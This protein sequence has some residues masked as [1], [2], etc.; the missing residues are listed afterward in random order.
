MIRSGARPNTLA[1]PL[2]RAACS[3]ALLLLFFLCGAKTLQNAMAE[4]NT[5]T[6]SVVHVDTPESIKVT[7]KRDGRHVAPAMDK[8]AHD[9]HAHLKPPAKLSKRFGLNKIRRSDDSAA[10]VAAEAATEPANALA[11]AL[12]REARARRQAT[13]GAAAPMAQ[14]A[15][16]FADTPAQPRLIEVA[17]HTTAPESSGADD[18]AGPDHPTPHQIILDRGY[19]QGPPAHESGPSQSQAPTADDAGTT[20]SISPSSSG[21]LPRNSWSNDSWSNDFW[22]NAPSPNSARPGSSWPAASDAPAGGESPLGY[23]EPPA[24]TAPQALL[25]AAMFAPIAPQREH[26]PAVVLTHRPPPATTI[27]VKRGLG[28]LASVVVSAPVVKQNQQ[29]PRPLL[30]RATPSIAQSSDPWLLAVMMSP[31]VR[32]YLTTLRLGAQDFRT[33]SPLVRKPE[34][35]VVMTFG[36]EPNPGLSQDHFTGKAV[37]F[38]WTVND[39]SHTAALP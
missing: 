25:D 8:I 22:S 36:T 11:A 18:A 10:A 13:I 20:G 12:E 21:S 9:E 23:A 37:V 34:M 38:L 1:F 30:L 29:P 5:R 32:R 27:A 14:E 2:Q 6:V 39:D 19:W 17:D 35:S 31:S 28:E 4:G 16:D 3:C 33:L 15:V 26:A 7:D 24:G